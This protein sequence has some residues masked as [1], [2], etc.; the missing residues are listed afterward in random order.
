MRVRKR[1]EEKRYWAAFSKIMNRWYTG[2]IDVDEKREQIAR[3]N[4][5]YWG[6]KPAALTPARVLVTSP[7][8]EA[9]EDRF[10]W[11]DK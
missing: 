10:W 2:Q 8:T 3:L 9:E 5:F 6:D 11:Q 4:E 7:A 1:D